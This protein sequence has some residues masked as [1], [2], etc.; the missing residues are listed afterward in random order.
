MYNIIIQY[1]YILQNGHHKSL[2]NIYHHTEL[3]IIFS[4]DENF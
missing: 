4:Y 3:Q 1:A 2:V